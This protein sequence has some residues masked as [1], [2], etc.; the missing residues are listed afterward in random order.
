MYDLIII[1]WWASWLFCSINAPKDSKKLIIERQE[2]LWNKILL[3]G[4]GRCNFTN[5][6]IDPD[7]YFWQ[8]KKMLSSVF[9][10]YSNYDFMNFLDENWIE[11][12]IEDNG[13]VILK[14]WKAK[15]LLEFLIKKS[16]E[17]NTEI[18]TWQTVTKIEKENDFFNF[19][20]KN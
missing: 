12:N 6:N 9:H 1:W 13:R 2:S 10:K 5:L 20:V 14:S 17:N 18:Q 7:R 3:S 8:N 15:E 16:E 11:Y 4:W 19:Y